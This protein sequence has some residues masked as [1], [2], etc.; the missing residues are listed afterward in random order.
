L[1]ENPVSLRELFRRVLVGAFALVLVV[2]FYAMLIA[3]GV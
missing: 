3:S 1:K 2:T